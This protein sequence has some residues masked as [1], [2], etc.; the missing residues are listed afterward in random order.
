MQP[1]KSL[2]YILFVL[3][4][5]VWGSS[6]ILMKKGLVTFSGTQIGALRIVFATLFTSLIGYK[7]FKTFK[8]ADLGPLMVVGLFG[9]AI[10]YMLFPIAVSHIDSSI[11]GITNSLTPLFTIL[12]G[13]W[14]FKSPIKPIQFLGVLIGFAGAFFLI[15]PKGDVDWSATWPYAAISILATLCYGISINTIKAKLSHLNSVAITLHSLLIAAV[16]C[17]IYLTLDP[18]FG[19]ALQRETALQSLG[20][21]SILGIVGS[22]LAIIAFNYLIKTASSIFAASITYMVP[23]VAMG[24]G[25]LD[26]ELIDARHFIGIIAILIGVYLVNYKGPKIKKVTS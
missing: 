13:I 7:H 15:Q 18:H 17:V 12:I 22:S 6:F 10:P 25:A 19:E 1:S 8:R 3:L 14:M 11:V 16:P 2:P 4:T 9:N 26:G 20:F 5:L 23:I 24:W 21:I